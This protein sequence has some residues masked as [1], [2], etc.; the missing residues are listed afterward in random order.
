MVIHV[1]PD[2]WDREAGGALAAA[3]AAGATTQEEG[4]AL[5]DLAE[6][7]QTALDARCAVARDLN[8]LEG[9]TRGGVRSRLGHLATGNGCGGVF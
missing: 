9:L 3:E 5:R 7:R 2:R 4:Q 8:S 1:D 6:R